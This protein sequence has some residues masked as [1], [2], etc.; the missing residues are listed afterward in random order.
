MIRA[1]KTSRPGNPT[2][3]R[4]YCQLRDFCHI[5][6]SLETFLTDAL[7]PYL[8]PSPPPNA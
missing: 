6:P 3:I 5:R 1:K 7:A 2:R 4:E 8:S